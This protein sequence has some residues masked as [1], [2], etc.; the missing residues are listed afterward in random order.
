MI[1]KVTYIL[2]FIFS[3]GLSTSLA[4]SCSNNNNNDL[5]N[6]TTVMESDLFQA[7]SSNNL[8]RVQEIVAASPINLEVKNSKGETPL[9]V[10][11]YKQYNAIAFYLIEQGANVNT[12]DERLNSPFL[13]AG[14]EGNLALVKKALAH[15]ADFTVFNRYH[16]TALIPAAE[17]GHLAVVQLLV[18]TPYFP[19]DHVNRL[20]WT[21]L[22]E[23]IV[24][25]DGG[26]VHTAIVEALI[27]GGVD[28][29]IPDHD[30]KTPLYHAKSRKFT[31]II[32]LLEAAGAHL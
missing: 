9:M 19:I 25:S 16:G 24:L 21:A 32:N 23:A 1:R 28:V 18:Q 6:T 26:D 14:A 29:N 4:A 17:K 8:K 5:K 10:A 15:G 20:G 22:M 11:T 12:Q 27:K 31:D 13:Y 3:V 30:G 2:L 7:V